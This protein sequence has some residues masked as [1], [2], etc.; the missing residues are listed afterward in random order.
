MKKL[1]LTLLL[2]LMVTP[3]MGD[4]PTRGDQARLYVNQCSLKNI[5]AALSLW[6]ADHQMAFPERLDDLVPNYNNGF[7]Q[8]LSELE[9]FFQ[10]QHFVNTIFSSRFDSAH[11]RACHGNEVRSSH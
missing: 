10:V 1:T 4:T 5:G 7:I 3:A 11:P 8:M 9:S 2:A 6:Q